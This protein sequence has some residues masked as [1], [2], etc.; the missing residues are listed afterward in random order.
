MGLVFRPEH[1][2]PAS[3]DRAALQAAE[4]LPERLSRR[5]REGDDLLAG[6]SGSVGM[7]GAA[8]TGASFLNAHDAAGRFALAVDDNP[9]FQGDCLYSPNQLVKVSL[10]DKESIAGLDAVIVTAYL[11]REVILDRL[12]GLGFN[13]IAVVAYPEMTDDGAVNHGA[14]PVPSAGKADRGS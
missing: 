5:R 3:T 6:I 13:G 12:P 7:Y 14:E 2:S 4:D 9:H 11:H 8:W 10:P 1:G